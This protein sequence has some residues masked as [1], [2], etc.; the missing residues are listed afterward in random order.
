MKLNNKT[1]IKFF[2]LKFKKAERCDYYCCQICNHL[3][4][5]NRK[6]LDLHMG[7]TIFSY[8]KTLKDAVPE[9]QTWTTIHTVSSNNNEILFTRTIDCAFD[10]RED[11]KHY[12]L[13]YEVV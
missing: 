9:I 1:N 13:I 8:R 6:I 7:K 4:E 11:E 2:Q 10:K 3:L 12:T 5:E